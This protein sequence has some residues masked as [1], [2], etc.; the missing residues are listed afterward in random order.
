MRESPNDQTP[1][2]DGRQDPRRWYARIQW[3]DV[4]FVILG[5]IILLMMT[6]ELWL[7]HHPLG[8]E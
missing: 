8:P 5:V 7:P 1:T 2:S 3:S 4:V 6:F